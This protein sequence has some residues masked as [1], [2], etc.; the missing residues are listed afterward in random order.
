MRVPSARVNSLDM[1]MITNVP[2]VHFA[3]YPDEI[4]PAPSIVN[5]CSIFDSNLKDGS[6]N[7]HHQSS[8]SANSPSPSMLKTSSLAIPSALRFFYGMLILLAALGAAVVGPTPGSALSYHAKAGSRQIGKGPWDDCVS[9]TDGSRLG[10]ICGLASVAELGTPDQFVGG[11]SVRRRP[12]NLLCGG[13][14]FASRKLQYSNVRHISGPTQIPVATRSAEENVDCGQRMGQQTIV[15]IE[16]ATPKRH[17]VG[18]LPR[19][20][21]SRHDNVV[22]IRESCLVRVRSAPVVEFFTGSCGPARSML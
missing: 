6:N 4:K 11:P 9:E 22:T 18:C 5:A 3:R 8:I 1:I 14:S 16:A 13:P 15:E 12:A 17:N 20:S 21:E 2:L 10:S 7:D 19:E